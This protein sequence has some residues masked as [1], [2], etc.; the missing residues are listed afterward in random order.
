MIKIKKFFKSIDFLTIAIVFTLFV[1]GAVALFSANGGQEAADNE[2]MKQIIWFGVGIVIMLII[3][4]I[5]YEVWGKLW[6]PLYALTLL[7]LFLVLFTE[8]INRCDEL[9]YNRW[10]KHSAF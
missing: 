6:I 7:M 4:S 2:Y 8:P 1:I 5:D 9:V 3:M 10:D